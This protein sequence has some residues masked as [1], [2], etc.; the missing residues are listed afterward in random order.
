GGKHMHLKRLCVALGA[1]AALA[2]LP[3]FAAGASTQFGAPVKVT[4]TGGHGYEPAVYTDH[5]GDIFA[6]AHK[7]NWQ[8]ALA[9][10]PN[11]P[12]F[13][14][15]MS[16]AWASSD[17]GRTF[18][19]LPGLTPLSLEQHDFG[20]EGDMAVDDANHL[21]FVD[22]NVGDVTFTSWNVYGRGQYVLNTHRPLLP[23]GEPVDDRPWVTAHGNGHVF[24]FGNEGD[25]DTY[26]AGRY[27]VYASYDGGTTFDPVGKTLVDS[28]WCR[29]AAD[30][31]AGSPYVYA[32]C[33]NDE[34]TLYSYVSPDDGHTFARYKAGMYAAADSTQS[35]PTVEVAPDG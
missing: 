30:H 5:Y 3:G 16:W 13:T 14:R 9:P 33:T 15:S 22:T 17:G 34:G 18:A 21:Y 10:D 6:T 7:E 31:R 35:W 32:F 26:G 20:D 8:L 27:T 23:A 28:G 11:S 1:A 12:T 2:L 29:P 4:P 25:K 24:Y 19:D